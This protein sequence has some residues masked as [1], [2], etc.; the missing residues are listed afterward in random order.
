MSVQLVLGSRPYDGASHQTSIIIA[1]CL[2]GVFVFYLAATLL[3]SSA[4]VACLIMVLCFESTCFA[5]IHTLALRGLRWHNKLIGSML[6]VAISGTA[7]DPP[8]I[9]AAA[10][11][12]GSF[13]HA[14]AVS[15]DFFVLAWV[16]PVYA[17]LFDAKKLD[18]HRMTDLNIVPS[19]QTDKALEIERAASITEDSKRVG[20]SMHIDEFK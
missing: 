9:G 16:Y 15:T 7:A 8:M 13:Y 10:T 20:T 3:S 6:V 2:F 11:Y 5:V 12:Q 4:L 1:I 17:N 14:M 18:Q 19:H